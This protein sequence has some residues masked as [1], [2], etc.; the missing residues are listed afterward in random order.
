[1]SSAKIA[2]ASRRYVLLGLAWA[3]VFL[4]LG[5][6][7]S[8]V[9]VH[10]TVQFEGKP[11]EEGI[12][13]LEPADGVGPSTGGSITAGQYDL[14]GNARTTVGEKVVRIYASRATGR[15][16]PAGSPAPPGTMVEEVVQ[17]IPKQYND[18]SNLKVRITPGRDNKQD[19]DLPGAA[20]P[21]AAK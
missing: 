8:R 2:S 19:F 20:K 5:C 18:E 12:I 15:K 21:Q 13:S 14:T 1:M 11:V 17:C 7:D 10:G 9:R 6:G 16:I 4:A 3:V